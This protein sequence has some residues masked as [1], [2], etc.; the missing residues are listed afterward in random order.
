MSLGRSRLRDDAPRR[1]AGRRA[2]AT[3]PML[4][5]AWERRGLRRGVVDCLVIGGIGLLIAAPQIVAAARILDFTYRGAHGLTVA[6]VSAHSLPPGR[7]LELLL[8][9]PWGWPSNLDRFGYWSSVTPLTPYIYSFYCGVVGLA[10]ALAAYRRWRWA[11]LVVAGLVFGWMGGPA[12][13]VLLRLTGGLFRFS[14]K[15]LLWVTLALALLAGWGFDRW[16]RERD[17]ASTA[18]SR[19]SLG[20]GALLALLA[21]LGLW[22]GRGP[23]RDRFVHELGA[24][25]HAVA[26]TQQTQWFLGALFAALLLTVA[27]IGVRRNRPGLVLAAQLLALAQLLPLLTTARRDEFA[28]PAPW[29]VMLRDDPDVV[30]LWDVPP[31]T[32]SSNR[33]GRAFESETAAWRDARLDLDVATGALHGLRYPQAP[34]FDGIYSPLSSLLMEYQARAPWPDRLRWFRRQGVDWFVRRDDDGNPPPGS[35][36]ARDRRYGVDSELTGSQTRRAG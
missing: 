15:F 10:A 26:A 34:D 12:A 3:V 29:I 30:L 9:L 14:Q 32:P 6:Q 20:A 8:P 35:P 11:A 5:V 28:P 16:F 7:W 17:E 21:A 25:S 22:F 4:L 13:E 36:V 31:S 2:L 18:Q 1:R 23:I 33:G 24:R 27:A 19:R